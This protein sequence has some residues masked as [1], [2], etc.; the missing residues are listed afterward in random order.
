MRNPLTAPAEAYAPD[1]NRADQD[2]LHLPGSPAPHLPGPDKHAELPEWVVILLSLVIRFVLMKFC[3]GRGRSHLLP[4][5]WQGRPDLPPGSTES[6]A[7]AL[8]GPF[9]NM[10]AWMCLRHGIGPGHPDW[11]ERSRAIMAFGGS[12]ARFR[13]GDPAWGLQWWENP[14]IVHGMVGF[15]APSPAA[16][17]TAMLAATATASLLPWPAAADSPSPAPNA[18]FAEAAHAEAA[19]ARLPASWR[20][21]LARAGPGPPTGPPVRTTKSVMSDERGR[22][23]VGPAVLIRAA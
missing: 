9:G 13:A 12:V 15:T 18:A 21:G 14:N 16:A 20:Q 23:T 17:A 8:R 1:A 10:I 2:A 5:W 7:A 19:H 22:S 3:G 6:M 11:P 4:S